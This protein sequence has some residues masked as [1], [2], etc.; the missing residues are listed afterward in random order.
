MA[1]KKEDGITYFSHECKHDANLEYIEAIHGLNGYALYFKLLERIYFEKGYYLEWNKK[2]IALF[3]KSVVLPIEK[4]KEIVSDMIEEGLF[5]KGIYEKHGYL[6][7]RGIQKRYLEATKRRVRVEIEKEICLV[8]EP[9]NEDVNEIGENEIIMNTSCEHNVNSMQTETAEDETLSPE[10]STE[11]PQSK[12]KQSKVKE[13]KRNNSKGNAENVNSSDTA[14]DID[15]FFENF[16]KTVFSS[17]VGENIGKIL[18]DAPKLEIV[19]AHF[20]RQAQ[21][22]G[23]QYEDTQAMLKHF[24]NWWN[25][26]TSNGLIA[27]LVTDAQKLESQ[28]RSKLIGKL[29]AVTS[30]IDKIRK[31]EFDALRKI[32]STIEKIGSTLQ[33]IAQADV[34]LIPSKQTKAFTEALED[35][36]QFYQNAVGA[37]DSTLSD[38]VKV[39]VLEPQKGTVKTMMEQL[40]DKI[41]TE[42]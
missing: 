17:Y 19:V 3:A 25:K 32:K 28:Q 13:S 20:K 7:S 34:S 23:T 42:K 30:A 24:N 27:R 8:L 22:K 10:M 31:K 5:D 29:N 21:R 1:R 15:L 11:M 14:A 38:F 16:K 36:S 26:S 12:V 18:I 9:K 40:R 6:T 35:A 39:V 41:G 4:T 2:I 33:E 37:D